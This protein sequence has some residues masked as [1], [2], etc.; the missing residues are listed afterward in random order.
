MSGEP[1]RTGGK[2]FPKPEPSQ[3]SDLLPKDPPES[4][5]PESLPPKQL[6]CPV[7]SSHIVFPTVCENLSNLVSYPT[8]HLSP[9]KYYSCCVKARTL[10]LFFPQPVPTERSAYHTRSTIT[11][12]MTR[13]IR[14]G[15]DKEVAQLTSSTRWQSQLPYKKR[16][17]PFKKKP[18]SFYF[19]QGVSSLDSNYDSFIWAFWK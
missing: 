18:L 12:W 13:P 11:K 8:N 10:L 19:C 1:G 15:Q 6:L 7:P 2:Q 4:S 5:H 3:G 9:H 17:A 14:K 16:I